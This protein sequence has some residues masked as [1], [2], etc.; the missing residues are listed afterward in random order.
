MVNRITT[1]V[2]LEALYGTPA[3]ISVA[4]ETPSINPEY[5]QLIEAAPLFAIATSGAEGMDCSPRGDGPGCVHILDDKTI[6]FADRRG[7]NRVDT[8]RNIIE[9]NRVGLLFFIP[10]WNETLRINGRAHIMID[11]KLLES[12][13]MN[14][15]LP[16]SVISIEI[17]TMYFQCARALKRAK[18]WDIDSQVDR[19]FIPST[20]Q[21][22]KS[23]IKSFD[24]DEYDSALQE[25]QAKTLY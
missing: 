7:N 5:R 9:D 11:P 12:F 19:K 2:E 13:S 10:G 3:S 21:L 6:A 23:V 20:G 17:D 8:L 14:G 16:R 25:R 24:G 22:I 18:F 15:K 4:K 1:L